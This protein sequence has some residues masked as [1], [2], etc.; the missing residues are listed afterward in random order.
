MFTFI[1]FSLFTFCYTHKINVNI[2][3]SSILKD[4][5]QLKLHHIV[6]L[7]TPVDKMKMET[8]SIAMDFTPINQ[9]SPV[10]LL[11]L[12][13]GINVPGEIR[14]RQITYKPTSS[15]NTDSI[16][17]NICM[18]QDEHISKQI[19]LQTVQNIKNVD[20]NNTLNKILQWETYM[21]LYTHN[22]QHFSHFVKDI[23]TNQ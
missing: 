9:P 21:N 12:L 23:I 20:L 1:F 8:E 6:V 17:E 4:V 22:C 3:H 14:I 10:T 19:S 2:I 11:K 5:P 7:T 18:Q 13:A 16:I 15:T